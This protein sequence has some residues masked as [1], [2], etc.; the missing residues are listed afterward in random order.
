MI[1]FLFMIVLLLVTFP[2]SAEKDHDAYIGDLWKKYG[3]N[4]HFKDDNSLR[5]SSILP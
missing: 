4:L 5:V 2:A 1:K 3:E